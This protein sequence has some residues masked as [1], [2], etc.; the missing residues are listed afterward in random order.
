MLILPLITSGCIN[1]EEYVDYVEILSRVQEGASRQQVLEK[2]SDAWFHAR[3]PFSDG[4]VEDIFFYGPRNRESVNL[5]MI[6]VLSE[7]KGDDLIVTEAGTYE[8]YF[9]DAPD[10]GEHCLPSPQ[11]AFD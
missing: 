8:S 1:N 3:C 10:F 5:I 11:N 6:G 4:A 2:L 9:L 7:P